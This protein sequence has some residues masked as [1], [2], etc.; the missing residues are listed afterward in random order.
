MLGFFEAFCG[1]PAYSLIVDYF[2]PEVRTTANAVYAFGIYVGSGLSSI[3][4][5][6]IFELGWRWTYAITGFIGVAIGCIILLIVKDPIRGRYEPRVA[7]QQVQKIEI[8]VKDVEEAENSSESQD[9]IAVSVTKKENICVKYLGG[10]KAMWNN[11]VCFYVVLGGCFRFWQG[12]S[13]AYFAQQYFAD[14]HMN[15]VYGLLNG[16][17]VMIGGF[18]S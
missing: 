15:N 1:P 3:I 18:S 7:I 4:N 11:K 17:S 8:E 2:P 9:A 5:I 16:L 6:M 14:Y 13:I 12:Y 10:F